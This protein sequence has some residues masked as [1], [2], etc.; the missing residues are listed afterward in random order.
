MPKSR[1]LFLTDYALTPLERIPACGILCERDRI[2]GTGGATAFSLL[3]EGLEIHDFTDCYAVPGFIDSHIHGISTFDSSNPDPTGETLA[4]MSLALVRHGVTTFC[5]TMVSRPAKEMLHVASAL[6]EMIDRG[7]EG[8]D[9][10]GIHVEGPFLSMSK[11]GSQDAEAILETIDLGLA[12]E[13]MEAGKGKIRIM[14]F[15]PE[16]ENADKLVELMLEHHVI[17][18][19]GHSLATEEQTYRCIDAGAHRCTYIFNGM[20]QL[21]HRESS[22]TSVALCDDRVAI[23]M[24]S[25]GLHIHPRF[26]DLTTRCKPPD[27]I[28][29][30]SNG[31]A[32]LETPVA[33]EDNKDVVTTSDGIIT[34]ST[35]TLENSWKH[36][37][38]YA[39]MKPSLAASCFTVNPAANLGLTNRGELLPGRRADIVFFD[40]KTNQVR[41]TVV[42]GEV[43]YRKS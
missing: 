18:S 35:M 17:P 32:S 5:P 19:M 3:E 10:A 8:A 29:G 30:I 28:I 41:A 40:L 13:I 4:K 24:I 39:G 16:L 37:I 15:A 27:K 43:I 33:A 36:L 42:R 14:T 25:D 12:R 34:G 2:I 11:R 31:V 21:H 22:L 6:A 9:I 7:V 1:K 20:P 26:V 23:E 38:S